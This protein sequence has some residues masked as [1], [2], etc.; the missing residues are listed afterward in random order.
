VCFAVV[1]FSLASLHST[2]A[3]V[4]FS[5]ANWVSMNSSIPGASLTVGAAV[6]DGSGNLYIGGHFA[7]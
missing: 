1:V 5:D 6:V 7:P 3:A 2:V 4:T